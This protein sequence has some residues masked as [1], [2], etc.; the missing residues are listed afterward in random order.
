MGNSL[1]CDQRNGRADDAGRFSAGDLGNFAGRIAE[2]FRHDN[3]Q[4]LADGFISRIAEEVF[5]R[6]VPEGDRAGAIGADDP[7]G[8]GRGDIVEA[9]LAGVL[10]DREAPP[11][12]LVDCD[13]REIEQGTAV[14]FAE[15]VAWR[16]VKDAEVAQSLA[17]SR[18]QEG[19]CKKTN[20]RRVAGTGDGRKSRIARRIE[21]DEDAVAAGRALRTQARKVNRRRIEADT[22]LQRWQVA[23]IY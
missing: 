18:M 19:A 8:R 17:G 5:G 7:V 12:D 21:R 10:G 6:I 16:V 23:A 2:T 11:F 1:P 22:H 3:A 13:R 9:A 4:V 15:L 14:A 20:L